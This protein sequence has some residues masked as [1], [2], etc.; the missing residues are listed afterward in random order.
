MPPQIAEGD[1]KIFRWRRRDFQGLPRA[2][3]YE[4]HSLAMQ[5]GQGSQGA[6]SSIRLEMILGL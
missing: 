3:V 4:T 1:L 2:R 6:L 5:R